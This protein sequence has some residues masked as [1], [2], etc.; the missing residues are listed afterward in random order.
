VCP[1]ALGL[2]QASSVNLR[3]LLQAL[4]RDTVQ[5]THPLKSLTRPCLA[6]T[7]SGLGCDVTRHMNISVMR[8][9]AKG[10]R[11]PVYP[12][13]AQPAAASCW[14]WQC[15]YIECCRPK[16][17][18]AFPI[19]FSSS[20]KGAMSPL[21]RIRDLADGFRA[22]DR[23]IYIDALRQATQLDSRGIVNILRQRGVTLPEDVT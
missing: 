12:S 20:P 10:T 14:P 18:V 4:L 21:N 23:D 11:L 2:C 5:S 22:Q 1:P 16:P 7:S 19:S 13:A 17:R 6:S 3:K 15:K 8:K 9:M